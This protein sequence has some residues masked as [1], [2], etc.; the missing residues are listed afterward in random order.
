MGLPHRLGLSDIIVAAIWPF[1]EPQLEVA[2]LVKLPFPLVATMRERLIY[3]SELWPSLQKL[4][5]RL[6]EV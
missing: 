5:V 2:D 4:A 3:S 1:A 6:K